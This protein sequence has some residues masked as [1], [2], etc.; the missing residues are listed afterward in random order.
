MLMTEIIFFYKKNIANLLALGDTL[1]T[2]PVEIALYT[3]PKEQR[4]DLKNPKEW[5]HLSG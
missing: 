3:P 1:S 2:C 5:K 4:G